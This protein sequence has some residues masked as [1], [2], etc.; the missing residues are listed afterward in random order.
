MDFL[1]YFSMFTRK[2]EFFINI[3]QVLIK[4][5]IIFLKYFPYSFGLF[6]NICE[7]LENIIYSLFKLWIFK[8]SQYSLENVDFLK[9]F[10][11]Y[12]PKN[13]IFF[14]IYQ[15]SGFLKYLLIFFLVYIEKY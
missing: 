12:T 10:I 13:L 5:W 4:T 9:T 7:F 15:K 6:K 3:I 2:Y 11:Q 8:K 1:K 14:N